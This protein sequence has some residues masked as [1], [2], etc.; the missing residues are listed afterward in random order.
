AA[1]R[2]RDRRIGQT[3]QPV[4]SKYARVCFEKGDIRVHNK[5]MADLIHPAH[6]LMGAVID[7]TLEARLPALKQGSVLVDPTDMGTEPQLL[8]MVAH[9]VRECTGSA[10]RTV[11]REGQFLRITP[12]GEATF[13]GWAPHLDL[14]PA[15]EA[16]AQQVKPLLEAAWLDQGLEQRA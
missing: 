7:M 3:R 16:E 1:I 4:L 11:S 13:A 12:A 10:E 9:E 14:R 6:P 15:T 8:L 2:E 5:P